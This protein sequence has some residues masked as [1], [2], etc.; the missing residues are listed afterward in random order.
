[1]RSKL[2]KVKNEYE[3][4]TAVVAIAETGTLGQ[5]LHRAIVFAGEEHG[6]EKLWTPVN[7]AYADP[8]DGGEDHSMKNDSGQFKLT[9]PWMITSLSLR[10][11]DGSNKQMWVRNAVNGGDADSASMCVHCRL[12]SPNG[13]VS[14]A[15]SRLSINFSIDSNFRLLLMQRTRSM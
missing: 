12:A 3:S 9:G 14:V 5:A 2:C 4:I 7:E 13:R 15:G 6:R 1:M 8:V 11:E 10:A